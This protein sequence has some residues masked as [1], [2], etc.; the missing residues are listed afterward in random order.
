MDFWND[1]ITFVTQK[2]EKC[3]FKKY[4]KVLSKK[5]FKNKTSANKEFISEV[6]W[7]FPNIYKRFKWRDFC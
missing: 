2:N 7:N 3:G 6:H 5:K 1:N 4:V